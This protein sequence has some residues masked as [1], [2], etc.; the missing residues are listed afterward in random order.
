MQKITAKIAQ[1]AHRLRRIPLHGLTIAKPRLPFC[2]HCSQIESKLQERGLPPYLRGFFPAAPPKI[3]YH[4]HSVST[5]L[6]FVNVFVEIFTIFA[7]ISGY[8]VGTIIYS[9]FFSMIFK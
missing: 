7:E 1:P 2:A 4:L 5:A 8:L 9:R 3:P 6:R